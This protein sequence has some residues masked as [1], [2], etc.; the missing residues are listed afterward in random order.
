MGT[1]RY[2]FRLRTLPYLSIKWCKHYDN[3]FPQ[4]SYVLT[5]TNTGFQET[6]GSTCHGAVRK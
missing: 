5:G 3:V 2:I 6:F 1:C 4:N